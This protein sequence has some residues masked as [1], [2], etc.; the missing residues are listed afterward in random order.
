EGSLAYLA[1]GLHSLVFV[2]LRI[3]ASALGLLL[4]ASHTPQQY[5]ERSVRTFLS[6][7]EVASISL[8]SSNLL[9][10]TQR[11]AR[12]LQTS[13]EISRAVTS[14]LDMA[15]LLPRVVNL[16]KDTFNYDHVQIFL[17]NEAHTTAVLEA[18]TGEAGRKML[19]LNWSLD[20]GSESV[21]GQV[22][23]RAEPVIAL[24]TI[25]AQVPHRPNP[26]LP[27]T[28]SEMAVPLKARGRVVGALD[29][30]SNRP[31][32]FS[33]EDVTVLSSLADQIAVALDNARL[34]E[35]TQNYTLA[36]AEQVR[37]LE[38][39]LD[40]SR[41]FTTM[42]QADEILAAASRYIVEL[43]G[44]DHCGIVINEGNQLGKL[45]AEHPDTGS[46]GVTFDLAS[47]AWW[48]TEYRRTGRPVI[49]QDVATTDQFDDGTRA[50]LSQLGIQSMLLVPLGLTGDRMIG[51]IGLDL[52]NAGHEF[53]DEDLTLLQLMATQVETAYQNAELFEAQ[54][55]AAQ[56]LEEQVH[57]LESLYAAS[58]SLTESLDPLD[59]ITT[60]LNSMVDILHID[61]GVAFQ[62]DPEN[63]AEAVVVASA[64]MDEMIGMRIHYAAMPFFEALRSGGAPAII[65]DVRA[66]AGAGERSPAGPLAGQNIRTMMIAPL[67]V[68]GQLLGA[69]GL[70]M[71][72]VR[73]YTPAELTLMQTI[74]AQVSLAYQNA[75]LFAQTEQRAEEMRFLFQVTRAATASDEIAVSMGSAVDLIADTINNDAV[76]VY[77]TTPEGDYLE[78]V[79]ARLRTAELEAPDRFPV[80]GDL[81]QSVI[82]S[83][84]P[85]I[86][87]DL[88][89][90]AQPGLIAPDLR[91]TILVPLF[92]G[93]DLLGVVTLFKREAGVYGEGEVNLMQT[94]SG[95]LSAVVQNI[96]LLEEVRAANERLR[97]VDKLKSQ[98]L[99]NMSHELRTPLNS[100]IG[101]SRVILKG[102]DGPLTDMQSQD[103]ETIHSNGQHLLRLINDIL[104]QSKIEAGKMELSVTWFDIEGVIEVARSMS[105]GLL[106]DKPVRLNIELEP[107]LPKVWGDEIRT[108]Q[109]LINLLSNAAKF[110]HEGSITVTAYR[111]VYEDGEYV[112]ISVSDTGIGIPADKFG[113]LFAAFEQ[114][115]GTLTRTT[116]GTGLGLPI[117]KS[118]IE[119]QGGE[120]WVESTVNVGSTF[121]VTIPAFAKQLE[122]PEDDE[123]PSMAEAQPAIGPLPDAALP[124]RKVIFVIDDEVGMHQLYRRYLN[125]AGYTVEATSDPFKAEELVRLIKPDI[126]L[127]DVRMP[128][129]DGWEVLS[130]LKDSDATF[131]IPVVVCS[132]DPDSER[133]FRLGA[134]DYL[135]KPFVEDDL[136][137]AIRRLESEQLRERILIIDDKPDTIRL[138]AEWLRVTDRYEVF[139]ATSGA[140]GLAMIAAKPPDLVLLDLN[141]PGMDGFAVLAA[142]R[143]DPVMQRV[144][145]LIITAEDDLRQQ[146]QELDDMGVYDKNALDEEQFLTDIEDLLSHRSSNGDTD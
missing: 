96:R 111:A 59:I 99:A 10:Q 139:T 24:D 75:Q 117:S 30:Q 67:Q 114:V 2:P 39:L 48:Q 82:N 106:K 27:D 49:V 136:L 93:D 83:R 98:F 124:A 46:I 146:A 103:L 91:S 45:R 20:V 94:L 15:Q 109:V 126:I 4:L 120:L 134:S 37:G 108:R 26:Y 40:A 137:A 5:D 8:Q 35:E 131:K 6:V 11:R 1:L 65:P 105:I 33:A 85:S 21:I 72:E 144:P 25:N 70:Y 87:D 57:R 140:D 63:P 95:S 113:V 38:E 127:L 107:N 61:C 77:L 121:S 17:L 19:N 143:A 43:M 97:E 112:Q 44:V 104:D 101:F 128:N 132:I 90:V 76:A 122:G 133:G 14:I 29:V 7:A 54:Q 64:G 18:S 118:L 51:S 71:R 129:R 22:T 31:G 88:Q 78:R 50:N 23:A 16:I 13:A 123:S 115:D 68:Q 84:A 69:F 86:I 81:L 58:L 135:V 130:R 55:E 12:Q 110:T 80:T 36:L 145:V 28:R 47:Q 62:A 89:A 41:S 60:A 53:A 32:A 142:M 100:I 3:G 116:G 92:S 125:K 79:A 34:F 138:L 42:L 74:T 56:A 102:I 66:L 141:M 119:M 73:E 52:Y 9:A